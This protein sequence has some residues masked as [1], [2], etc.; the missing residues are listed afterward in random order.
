[1][2]LQ[3]TKLT[4]CAHRAAFCSLAGSAEDAEEEMEEDTVPTGS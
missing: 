4:A 1:M 3:S 2:Q